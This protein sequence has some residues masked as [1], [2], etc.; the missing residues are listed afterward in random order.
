M[1][2]IIVDG[3]EIESYTVDASTLQGVL[4]LLA[5]YPYKDVYTVLHALQENSVVNYVH[6]NRSLDNAEA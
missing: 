4:N 2:N 1:A 3:K 5:G 6:D